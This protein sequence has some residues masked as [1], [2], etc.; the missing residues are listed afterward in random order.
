MMFEQEVVIQNENG[1][2]VR[3]AAMIVQK[4]QELYGK[5]Q[6][7]LYIRSCRSQRIEL[8]NLM[9][10]V[11]LKVQRGDTVFVS[12]EGE[13]S[14]AAVSEMAAFLVGDFEMHTKTEVREVD[15]LLHENALMQD[16]LQMILEAVQDGICV[17]DKTGEVTYVN[18]SYL[19]IVHKTSK[20]IPI[21]RHNN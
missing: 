6:C 3:V 2:H 19:R 16:R 10:L 17:V 1:L 11:A 12:A 8:H 4:A 18:P 5:H 13:H 15:R 9:L 20:K 7:R 14:Q 21:M